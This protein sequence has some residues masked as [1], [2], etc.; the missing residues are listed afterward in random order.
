MAPEVYGR[1]ERGEFMP[2]VIT[3]VNIATVLRVTPDQ[4]LGWSE[5]APRDRAPEYMRIVAL[6]ERADEAS[7][8]RFEAVL[9][10]LLATEPE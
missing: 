7:L 2:S 10:A 1:I 9:Q 4:L 5:I 8:R 6:L 3:L